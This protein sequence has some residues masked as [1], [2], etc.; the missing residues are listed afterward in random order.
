MSD[1]LEL[2]DEQLAAVEASERGVAVLA[3]P[4]SGKTRVLSYRARHLLLEDSGSKALLLTFTNKAAA[5]MKSRAM[6]VATVASDRIQ[7]QTYHSLCMRILRAHGSLVGIEPDFEVI[8]SDEQAELSRRV[9]RAA[10]VHN[11][12]QQW[13]SQRLRRLLPKPAVAEFGAVYEEEKRRTGV[14]DF[15]DLI[16]YAADLLQQQPEIAAAYGSKYRHLLIDEFQDTNAAQFA[17]VRALASNSVTVSVFAD[18]DQAIFRFAGAEAAHIRRFCEE[19]QAEIY[20]LTINYRC[21][22]EIV[23]CANRLILADEFSSGRKMR[24]HRS[25]GEVRTLVFQ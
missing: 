11:R 18:D 4:G 14:V 24:A 17:V 9:A 6:G 1:E 16:V 5:E 3:G 13:S 22:E 19:L 8:D 12:R 10:G 23:A 25:G 2:D 20:P 15:D 21:R 7:S